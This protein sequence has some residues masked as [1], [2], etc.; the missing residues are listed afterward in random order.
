MV[1]LGLLGGPG[2]RL[3]V[4]LL[5]LLGGPGGLFGRSG[6]SSRVASGRVVTNMI[7]GPRLAFVEFRFSSLESFSSFA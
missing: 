1:L 5:D 2:E 3:E 6:R 4:V 7:K